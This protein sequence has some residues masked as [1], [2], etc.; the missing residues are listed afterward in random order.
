M[1]HITINVKILSIY[2]LLGLGNV[3]FRNFRRFLLNTKGVGNKKNAEV[4]CLVRSF[5]K[6]TKLNCL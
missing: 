1:L 6:G 4:K 5:K 3:F 2:T